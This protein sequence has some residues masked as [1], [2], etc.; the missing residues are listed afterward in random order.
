[1]AV[2]DGLTPMWTTHNSSAGWLGQVPWAR[3]DRKPWQYYLSEPELP[4]LG[5]IRVL[6]IEE[7]GRSGRV[8]PDRR[9]GRRCTGRHGRWEPARVTHFDDLLVRAARGE[10]VAYQDRST[11]KA[12]WFWV[13]PSD[14]AKV[15]QER[16]RDKAAGRKGAPVFDADDRELDRSCDYQEAGPRD[17]LPRQRPGPHAADEPVMVALAEPPALVSRPARVTPV[18][19]SRREPAG[20]PYRLRVINPGTAPVDGASEASAVAN[21][22]VFLTAVGQLATEMDEVSIHS[23][24]ARLDRDPARDP[25][26]DRDGRFGWDLHF[27]DGHTVRLLMP[28]TDLS[29]V[30]DDITAQAPCLYINGNAWW[31]K[32]AVAMVAGEGLVLR[33][34][35]PEP[36][37]ES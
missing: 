11:R 30:R 17:R 18:P 3:L 33:S 10:F 25:A 27:S 21:L 23:R 28:G 19:S 31:W 4:V 7:C 24:S 8:C 26:A 34:T 36:G 1:M 12:N 35:T 14:L 29:A 20:Q 6:E 5:G 13:L 2:A 9:R 15:R 22:A 32:D 37:G 16:D